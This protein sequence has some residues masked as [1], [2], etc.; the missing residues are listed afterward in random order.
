MQARKRIGAEA[1]NTA[2]RIVAI[3]GWPFQSDPPALAGGNPD[4]DARE[5]V[6]NAE[7]T[8]TA[9]PKEARRL[10]SRKLSA[11]APT[12]GRSFFMSDL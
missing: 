6:L 11:A 2:H 10:G 3:P 12:G 8:E 1:P 7:R 5:E 9:G 4:V